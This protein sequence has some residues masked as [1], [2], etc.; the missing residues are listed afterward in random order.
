MSL[1]HT[2]IGAPTPDGATFTA[3]VD[4][5]GPVRV[6]V[7]DNASM[8]SP[9]FTASQ[10][11]DSFDMAK[12]SITGLAPATQYFWQ[13]EDNGILDTAATGRFR[14]APP[15][16]ARASFRFIFAGDAGAGDSGFVADRVSNHP[17]F[18]IIRESDPDFFIMPGDW[19]YRDIGSGE[20]SPS[21]FDETDYQA[22][23]SDSLTF[24]GTLGLSARQSQLAL[25][26]PIMATWDNH[27]YGSTTASNADSDRTL[28]HREAA[29]LS[30]QRN[31]P[32]YPLPAGTGDVPIYYDFPWG[33]LHFVVLDVRSERDPN[34]DPDDASKS[35][36]GA[37]Q[38][39]WLENLL[40]TSD[41]AALCVVSAGQWL[42]DPVESDTWA[43]YETERAEIVAMFRAHGWLHRMFMLTASKHA[44]GLDSGSGNVNGGFPVAL[45]A[46]L[47][48]GGA[49]VQQ[50]LYDQGPT[51]PGHGQ[52][53]EVTVTDLGSFIT[54]E[55]AGY[56][57]QNGL[58]D[59]ISFGIQVTG[60][61]EVSSA[62]VQELAPIVAG[63][64]DPTFEARILT[65]FQEGD[66]PAGTDLP[67]I[68][69]DV[70]LDATADVFATLNLTTQGT[71]PTTGR[72]WFPRLH[73][74]LLGPYGN[75]VFVRRGVD[76]G[77]AVL[78][79]P[80]GYFR[81]ETVEQD[82]A[83]DTPIR[84]SGSD[85]MAGIVEADLVAP[86]EFPPSTT[87][88]ALFSNLIGDVYPDATVVFDDDAGFAEI[89]RRLI[90]DESRYEPLR[91]AADGLGKVMRWDG[92]GSL[93]IESAPEDDEPVWR[94][95]A[96]R[97]G[98][99]VDSGR[100]TS[101][102]GAFNAVIVLGEA[103]S[104][105]DPVRGVAIDAGPK[106]PTRF[107][108]RFGQV[109]KVVQ[110]PTVT[111]ASQAATAAREMLRRNLGVPYAADFGAVTNPALQ[112]RH[113]ILV[114]RDD[115]TRENHIVQTLTI[116]LRVGPTMTGTTRE[117]TD[118]VIGS[119][120]V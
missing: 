85:R 42:T 54:V 98:V 11:V 116:P 83:S 75:E 118:L 111:T 101:R 9:V 16:G 102:I 94:V 80:L 71:D 15:A 110:L 23:W 84:L 3:R 62:Q 99:L 55:L 13:I 73:D 64:H 6:A 27:D 117:R 24:N 93:R 14:T 43:A 20:H 61:Q 79:V 37:E 28:P 88:A 12:V 95:A 17:V 89:G 32:H 44:L 50:N 96:G 29:R 82:D 8:S 47:D 38:K 5:G 92:D 105:D 91:E 60:S 113:P 90:V 66:D 19:G 112:P 119:A 103:G 41:A 68:D 21:P 115:G 106:S 109:P 51:Q 76:I 107:S 86:R 97:N 48:A 120:I 57:Y 33:R 31:V 4:G 1:V 2:M 58:W 63:S 74:D 36:L 81:I 52:Y 72:S 100:R 45:F 108:G 46:A 87:F 49:E 25:N 26:V 69:G 10:A 59:S 22:Q 114:I 7:A 39:A 77:S 18:D 35:M 56:H 65:T 67:I 104:T 53:G 70:Q 78:W 30:W 40:A 34:S